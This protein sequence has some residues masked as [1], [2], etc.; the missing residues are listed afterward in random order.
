MA[1][2]HEHNSQKDS[3][4]E[5]SIVNQLS[6]GKLYIRQTNQEFCYPGTMQSHIWLQEFVS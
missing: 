1:G 4:K 5:M 6:H 3:E 2:H